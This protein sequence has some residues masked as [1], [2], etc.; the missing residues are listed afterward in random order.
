MCDHPNREEAMFVLRRDENGKPTVWCDP[1][2]AQFVE[3]LLQAGFK[4][5]WS[6]CGHGRRPPVVGIEFADGSDRDLMLLTKDEHVLLD[7]VWPDI[8]APLE[9][10]L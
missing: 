6:C 7:S 3:M 9:K 2:L 4:T 10:K 1:C 8:N 5:T